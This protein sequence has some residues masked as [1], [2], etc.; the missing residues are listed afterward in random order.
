M[1]T[2]ETSNNVEN[3]NLAKLRQLN[4]LIPKLIEASYLNQAKETKKVMLATLKPSQEFMSTV[5]NLPGNYL[6]EVIKVY[7]ELA[8][9][10]YSSGQEKFPE[11]EAEIG[12]AVKDMVLKEQ[13]SAL[14][15]SKY[16]IDPVLCDELCSR[17]KLNTSKYLETLTGK[18]KIY[19]ALQKDLNSV[20]CQALMDATVL[21]VKTIKAEV[22]N[23]EDSEEKQK[24]PKNK[25]EEYTKLLGPKNEDV[26][27]V[28][29]GLPPRK[30]KT[31]VKAEAATDRKAYAT[32]STKEL[33]KLIANLC[34][35]NEEDLG[36]VDDAEDALEK[37]E[38]KSPYVAED[39]KNLVVD[40]VKSYNW[41]DDSDDFGYV[42]VDCLVPDAEEMTDESLLKMLS[43]KLNTVSQNPESLD[44][45]LEDIALKISAEVNL[46]G[47]FMFSEVDGDFCMVFTFSKQSA[48][49]MIKEKEATAA[50]HG[51]KT[52]LKSKNKKTVGDLPETED[53]LIPH[54][55]QKEIKE[56]YSLGGQLKNMPLRSIRKASPTLAD[57]ISGVFSMLRAGKITMGESAKRFFSASNE[58][59]I[60]E[61]FGY[62]GKN[63]YLYL[64]GDR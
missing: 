33:D 14:I 61:A 15:K 20:Y 62:G 2:K 16:S 26:L 6:E 63:Y 49:K 5:N 8:L 31:E 38:W 4:K 17:F 32:T 37:P 19:K 22:E 21:N 41:S 40:L 48:L 24:K 56:I 50:A 64:R 45:E 42:L 60:E 58:S 51:K 30:G 13:V 10:A 34:A 12:E 43:K 36:S 53:N 47:E 23:E 55:H 7:K 18:D 39:L 46:P 44:L 29:L 25:L 9:Q 35:S 3:L 1:N 59:L 27:R 28:T 52:I 57:L 11:A 54:A